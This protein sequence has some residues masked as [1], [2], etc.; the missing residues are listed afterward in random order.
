MGIPIWV[1]WCLYIG[2]SHLFYQRWFACFKKETKIFILYRASDWVAHTSSRELIR[3]DNLVMYTSLCLGWIKWSLMHIHHFF[4]FKWL[5]SF[6]SWYYWYLCRSLLMFI[7]YPPH[8]PPFGV[9]QGYLLR[10]VFICLS[11]CICP[12]TVLPFCEIYSCNTNGS[13]VM[14]KWYAMPVRR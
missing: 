7:T 2:L 9:K 4:F 10:P 8:P 6:S 13:Y 1:W 3:W 14:L 12:R 5:A 11:T